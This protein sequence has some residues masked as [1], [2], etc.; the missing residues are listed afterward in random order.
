MLCP[1]HEL[2]AWGYYELSSYAGTIDK[3][4]AKSQFQSNPKRERGI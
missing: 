1:N 2:F 4:K 3:P